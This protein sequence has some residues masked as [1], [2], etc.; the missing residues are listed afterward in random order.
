MDHQSGQ[1]KGDALK[2]PPF[3]WSLSLVLWGKHVIR[4]GL[5]GAA[6]QAGPVHLSHLFEITGFLGAG[7]FG[8]GKAEG[9]AAIRR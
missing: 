7:I 9:E 4:R 8:L 2:A 6:T 5:S 3:P 1:K